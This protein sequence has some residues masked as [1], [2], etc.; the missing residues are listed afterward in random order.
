MSSDF[1]RVRGGFSLFNEADPSKCPK[2]NAE[3]FG[4]CGYGRVVD[5][6]EQQE[7]K[8]IIECSQCGKQKLVNCFYDDDTA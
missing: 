5:C 7:D 4:Q 2:E 1:Q 6:C 8:D 3:V